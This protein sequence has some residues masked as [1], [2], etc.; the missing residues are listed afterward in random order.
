VAADVRGHN[1][2]RVLEVHDATLAIGEPP[3]VQYL[4]EDVEDVVVSLLDLIKQDYRIWPS[5]NGFGELPAL[6]ITDV[7]RRRSD[8]TRN[9]VLL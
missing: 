6:F 9:G 1:D 3:V 7:A 4:K 8:Q 5:S 2:D